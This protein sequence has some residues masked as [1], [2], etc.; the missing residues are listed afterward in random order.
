MYV[1]PGCYV[2]AFPLGHG[3]AASASVG[4]DVILLETERGTKGK[5]PPPTTFLLLGV[6]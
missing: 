4:A 3:L 6:A 5:G 1:P 2:L